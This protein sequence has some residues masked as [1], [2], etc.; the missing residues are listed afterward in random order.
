MMYKVKICIFA[1]T[2]REFVIL[3]VE[4]AAADGNQNLFPHP[5]K[6]NKK[7]KRCGQCLAAIQGDGYREGFRKL[8]AQGR[9]CQRCSVALCMDHM[10]IICKP[11][12]D[13]LIVKPPAENPDQE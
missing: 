5:W 4:D 1:R 9:Q 11:C 10:M 3:G 8:A 13:N 12:S 6:V 7:S 2:H